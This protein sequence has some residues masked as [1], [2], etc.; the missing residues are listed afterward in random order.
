M[1]EELGEE[2]GGATDLSP[3]STKVARRLVNLPSCG[4]RTTVSCNI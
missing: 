1:M 4:R 3:P 2:G